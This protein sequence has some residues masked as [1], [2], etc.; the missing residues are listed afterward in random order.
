LLRPGALCHKRAVGLAVSLR[1]PA[2]APWMTILVALALAGCQST[3]DHTTAANPDRLDAYTLDNGLRVILMPDRRL[4]RVRVSV[5][6]RVGALAEEPG[7]TGL[8]HLLEHLTYRGSQHSR[9]L[10]L[11]AFI[12]PG[13]KSQGVTQWMAT[14]Y[15]TRARAVDL[16]RLLWMESKRMAYF[17]PALTSETLALEQ[18]AVSNELAESIESKPNREAIAAIDAALYPEL[19]RWNH[20]PLGKMTDVARLTVTEVADFARRHYVP[21]AATLLIAG[22]FEGTRARALVQRWFG[23]LPRKPAPP[24]AR[25][26]A[27]PRLAKSR[28]QLHVAAAPVPLIAYGWRAPAPLAPGHAEVE[29]LVRLLRDASEGRFLRALQKRGLTLG[30]TARYLQ[31]PGILGAVLIQVPCAEGIPVESVEAALREELERL[32]REPATAAEHRRAITSIEAER[33]FELDSLEARADRLLWYENLVGHPHAL[34]R[35]LADIRN[36]TPTS[37]RDAARKLLDPAVRAEIVML[38]RSPEAKDGP[39]P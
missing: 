15:N 16:E 10:G 27:P 22:D 7:R 23:A 25:L 1:G 36:T 9:Q 39:R 24:P 26:D 33:L 19:A 12:G 38:P 35:E 18:Q 21:A 6:Y 29:V 4:P 20:W 3:R 31:A 5:W 14:Q 13:G 2:L 11:G 17:A 37:V 32:R 8:A 34:D 30:P 28:R